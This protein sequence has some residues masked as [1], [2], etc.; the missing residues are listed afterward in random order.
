MNSP[1]MEAEAHAELSGPELKAKGRGA[2]KSKLDVRALGAPSVDAK[3]AKKGKAQAGV[4]AKLK[5]KAPDVKAPKVKAEAKGS[6]SF[7]LGR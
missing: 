5:A 6:A 7:K 3:A 1:D 4:S 2:A